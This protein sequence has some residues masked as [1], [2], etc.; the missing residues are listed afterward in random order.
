MALEDNEWQKADDF[1]EQALNFDARLAKAYLG[2][3]MAE[4]KVNKQDDLQNCEKAFDNSLNYQ[5]TMRFA[6]EKLKN[7]LADDIDYINK[8]NKK[9]ELEEVYQ[10]GVSCMS[11]AVAEN[12]FIITAE[13]FEEIKDYKDSAM[14]AKK[15]R[16]NAEIVKEQVEIARKDEIYNMAKSLIEE[17]EID[18]YEEAI[19][20]L[21]TVPG[22]K[23]TDD[24][25]SRCEERI[26]EIK[27]KEEN[28]R[29]EQERKA[30]EKRILAEQQKEKRRKKVKKITIMAISVLCAIIVLNRGIFLVRSNIKY[31]EANAAADEELEKSLSFCKMLFLISPVFRLCSTFFFM[32]LLSDS[33]AILCIH[34][35]FCRTY[36]SEVAIIDTLPS[37]AEI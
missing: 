12:D 1:F 29:I 27:E 6:D 2:K 5:K 22:W 15:C 18:Y 7:S 23:D 4:L 34:D 13:L 14:L 37:P 30:E 31:N 8:R 3:L 24:L 25:I 17:D 32:P 9:A 11:E 16:E 33:A 36:P 10:D 26:K 21:K 35:P 19:A 28:A 20:K